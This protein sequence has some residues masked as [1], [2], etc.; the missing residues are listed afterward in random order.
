MGAKIGSMA[1]AR[2]IM[3]SIVADPSTTRN[4][5]DIVRSLVIRTVNAV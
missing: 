3:E 2:F 1:M 5:I 4:T